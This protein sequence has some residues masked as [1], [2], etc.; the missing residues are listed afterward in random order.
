[1][2][3]VEAAKHH[4]SQSPTTSGPVAGPQAHRA[5]QGGKAPAEREPSGERKGAIAEDEKQTKSSGPVAG[6]HARKDLQ[7]DMKTPGTGALPDSGTR[8][9]D[10]GPD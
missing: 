2:A 10:V 1:M 4:N 9:V 5:E 7:D 3:D 8:E 6:P